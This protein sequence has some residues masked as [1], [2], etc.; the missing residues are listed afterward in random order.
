MT[1]R[2]MLIM[3]PYEQPVLLRHLVVRLLAAD[4]TSTIRRNEGNRHGYPEPMHPHFLAEGYRVY[5]RG[6]QNMRERA[7][8]EDAYQAARSVYYLL[9]ELKIIGP[10][11]DKDIQP[12][13]LDQR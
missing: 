12:R 11:F 1:P 9:K 13:D 4:I 8:S 5:H 6:A 3:S 2:G 7:A 10:E